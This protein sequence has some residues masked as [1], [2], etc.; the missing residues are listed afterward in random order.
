MEFSSK[1][2]SDA[3]PVDTSVFHLLCIW[4][5]EVG[6]STLRFHGI[7]VILMSVG[8]AAEHGYFLRWSRDSEWECSH[9]SA[10][11]DWKNIAEPVMQLYTEATDGSSIEIKESALVWHHQDADPDFGS[12]QAKE[13]LDHL[14]SV[15]ANEPAV[16]N[17][18]QVFPICMFVKKFFI[19]LLS[20]A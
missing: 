5:S 11:L 14:E 16:G 7:D 2:S 8:L 20:K 1:F 12:C 18:L 6:T 10:D 3:E 4:V 9:L 13:L 15:L 17:K 19:A